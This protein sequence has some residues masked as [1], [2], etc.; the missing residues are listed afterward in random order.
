M[1]DPISAAKCANNQD[2]RD[3]TGPC[4]LKGGSVGFVPVRYA[5]DNGYDQDDY[6]PI[7]ALPK[8]GQGEA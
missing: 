7:F 3:P 1:S 4:P 8:N 2:S 6:T 5:F